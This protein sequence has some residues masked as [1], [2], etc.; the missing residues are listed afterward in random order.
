MAGT[1]GATRPSPSRFERATAWT[2]TT[3]RRSYTV[4]FLVALTLYGLTA[5]Y[6]GHQ[7]NDTQAV[8]WPAWNFVHHGTFMLE[9][10]KGVPVN[11][12]IYPANGHIVAGRMMG[13]ILIGVPVCAL[14][15]W[16]GMTPAACNGASAAVLTA[17]TI[18]LLFGTFRKLAPGRSALAAAAVVAFGTPLWSVA[19][20][21]T[22]PQTGDALIL[23]LMLFFLSRDRVGWAGI[24]LAPALMVRPHVAIVALIMGLGLA[25]R[26]RSLRPVLSFGVPA[27]ISLALLM[28]WNHWYFGIWNLLGAYHTQVNT[29]VTPTTG[30][31]DLLNAAGAFFTPTQGL[32]VFTPVIAL[33]LLWMAKGWRKAPSWTALALVAG[34]VYEL[35]QLRLDNYTGGGGFYGSR[36]TL[37][38]M[39]LSAPLAVACYQ[40]WSAGH[41]WRQFVTSLL[42][43][44]G[45]GLFAN[46]ALL[47]YYRVYSRSDQEWNTFYPFRKAVWAGGVGAFTTILILGALAVFAI[48]RF[49]RTRSGSAGRAFPAVELPAVEV[50]TPV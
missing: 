6:L 33:A 14:L 22:W 41:P 29:L 47:A 20:A 50:E 18:A 36:L 12:W 35:V 8:S 16:T 27:G 43:A 46:G 49:A 7:V 34:V 31:S 44:A 1:A 15:W 26:S 42:S 30:S 28:L 23:S 24:S 32:L 4:V 2:L 40:P 25:A 38:L 39:V 21:E 3:S 11:D 10:A 45:I 48:D 5:H 19:A 37:E 17:V 9:H 13:V